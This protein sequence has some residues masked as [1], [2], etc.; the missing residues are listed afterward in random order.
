MGVMGFERFFG[1][2]VFL[3]DIARVAILGYFLVHSQDPIGAEDATLV[4]TGRLVI[5]LGRLHGTVKQLGF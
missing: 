4:V 2:E 3:V 5:H 1:R